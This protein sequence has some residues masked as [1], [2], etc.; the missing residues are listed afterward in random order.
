MRHGKLKVIEVRG[1][2]RAVI[3]RTT[4][5][6]VHEMR[7]RSGKISLGGKQVEAVLTS[8]VIGKLKKTATGSG[9]SRNGEV[10]QR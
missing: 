7:D 8:G 1:N 2:R 4:S 5:E 10:P 3:V 6:A 9:T